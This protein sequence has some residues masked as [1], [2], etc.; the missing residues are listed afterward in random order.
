M[1]NLTHN[2]TSYNVFNS[3]IIDEYTLCQSLGYAR[4]KDLL[5]EHYSTL[6][7]EDDFKQIAEDGFNLVRIPIGY[8]A[9]K[10]NYTYDSYI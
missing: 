10:L 8:W 1:S 3:S 6:I 7:T 2:T 5:E 4:A 9:W